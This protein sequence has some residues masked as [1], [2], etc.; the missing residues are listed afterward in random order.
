VKRELDLLEQKRRRYEAKQKKV[1][2]K[3]FSGGYMDE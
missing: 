2:G 3:M 1:I